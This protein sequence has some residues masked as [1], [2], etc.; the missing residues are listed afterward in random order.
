[1]Y[2]DP[3]LN[4]F[5]LDTTGTAPVKSQRGYASYFISAVR[6]GPNGDTTWV[7]QKKAIELKPR[8]QAIIDYGH[9]PAADKNVPVYTGNSPLE[10]ERAK[11]QYLQPEK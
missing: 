5:V 1:M 10:I 6:A 9:L 2:I 7:N 8:Q 3:D 4:A 11:V